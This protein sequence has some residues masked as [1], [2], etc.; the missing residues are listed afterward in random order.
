MRRAARLTAYVATS[1]LLLTGTTLAASPAQAA[2]DPIGVQSGASWLAGQL[3]NGVVHNDQYDFDDYGLSV[4]IGLALAEVGGQ[5]AAIQAISDELASHVGSYVGSGPDRYAGALAKAAV[6]ADISGADPAAFGGTNLVAELEGRV[7]GSGPIAGRIEDA[8]DASSAWGADYAN[9]I[10]QA[11]AARALATA[12]SAKAPSVA[13][14]LLRQQCTSGYFRLNFTADKTSTDQGCSDTSDTPDTDATAI[15]VIELAGV[16][17]PGVAAGV[18]RA[19]AWLV[20]SQRPDGSWGG[21]TST[22]GANANSTGLAAWALGDTPESAA[23]AQWLREHQATHYDDCDR[24]RSERGA[25][26]YD[27]AGLDDA[28]THGIDVPHRDQWRRASAQAVPALAYLPVDATPASPSLSAPTSYLKAGSR[29][30]FTTSGVHTGDQLCLTGPGATIQGTA[31]GDTWSAA[32][33]LPAGTATRTYVVRDRDGH[34]AQR[35]V[36]V[37]GAKTLTVRR[38]KY[39]VKRSRYVTATVTGLAPGERAAVAYKGRVVK[40]GSA[41]AYGTFRARFVVG[42]RTGLKKITARG[43]FGDIRHGSTVI[44][45]VR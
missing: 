3:T 42:R 37:L 43:A 13:D 31:G 39:R 7:A 15:A 38:S 5:G 4:D 29:P 6:L 16:D 1:A 34:S 24:L 25:I 2:T 22:E 14:F 11:F 41:S 44:R 8:Y 27:D 9:S 32:P 28:R 18:S 45:V 36:K 12:R 20:A 19:R 40:R 26:A 35:S 23:A 17:E 10:G 21:G 30:T 33:V